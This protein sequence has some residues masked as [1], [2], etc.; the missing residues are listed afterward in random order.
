MPQPSGNQS[1]PEVPAEFGANEWLVEEMHEQYVKD[2]ASVDP[3]WASYFES[4]AISTL[5]GATTS[6][7]PAPAVTPAVNGAAPA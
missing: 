1:V 4:H 2:P 3:A 6:S 7:A 5:N